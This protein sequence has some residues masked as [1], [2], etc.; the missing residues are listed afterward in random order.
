M[1]PQS[2]FFVEKSDVIQGNA[3]Y[4]T[5]DQESVAT[6]AEVIAASHAILIARLTEHRTAQGAGSMASVTN[7]LTS[8]NRKTLMESTE[9]NPG[10]ARLGAKPDA[11]PA[12]HKIIPEPRQHPL[13]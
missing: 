8:R 7:D 11:E 5:F 9:V 13:T 10:G 4:L 6:A 12:T 2:P 1:P 3:T